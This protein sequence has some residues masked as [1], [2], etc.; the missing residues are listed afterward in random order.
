MGTITAE[1]RRRLLGEGGLHPLLAEL[2]R[3]V[4]RHLARP[5]KA[6]FAAL[7]ESEEAYLASLEESR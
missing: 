2:I 6:N 4:D 7:R 3:A 5:T 1:T